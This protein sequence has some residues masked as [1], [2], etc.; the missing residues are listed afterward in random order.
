MPPARYDRPVLFTDNVNIIFIVLLL[1]ISEI[2]AVAHKHLSHDMTKPTMWLCTQRSIHP[3]WS[4]SSL[5]AW[6][7]LGG[8]PGWS[9]SSL[10]AHSFCWFCHVA[11]HFHLSHFTRKPTKLP[12]RQVNTDQPG[13][14]ESSLSA[15]RHIGPL[16]CSEDSDQTGWM[17]RLIWVFA[18][19][20]HHFVGFGMRWL[21]SETF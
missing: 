3:V 20:I 12:V 21:I 16:Y 5:S 14:S 4:E 18:G 1:E 19:H 11:A 6:R 8:C 9:E 13:R 17:P 7:N 15:W 2:N 10:G